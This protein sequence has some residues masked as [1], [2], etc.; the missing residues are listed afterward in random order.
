V[1]IKFNNIL[2]YDIDKL[3]ISGV[4][5]SNNAIETLE[6]SFWCFMK[7]NSYRDSVIG[8]INLGGSTDTIGALTG[9]LAGVYYGVDTIPEYLMSELVNINELIDLSN[10]FEDYLLTK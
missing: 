10:R 9:A 7:G 4:K 3:D 6:A 5:S 2:R 8:A 1:R